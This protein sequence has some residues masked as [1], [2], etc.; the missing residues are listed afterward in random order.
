M[1]DVTFSDSEAAYDSCLWMPA[2]TSTREH[3]E[4]HVARRTSDAS[5]EL[6]RL[7]QERMASHGETVTVARRAVLEADPQLARCYNQAKPLRW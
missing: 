3:A 1:T 7:T 6:L 5:V 4:P 2:P